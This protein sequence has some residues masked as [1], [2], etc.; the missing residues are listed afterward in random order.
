[1]FSIITNKI[2]MFNNLFL[3]K[4]ASFEIQYIFKIVY[5]VMNYAF[6]FRNVIILFLKENFVDF[7]DC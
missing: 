1:M 3:L 6:V 2:F 4:L 7:I 5:N